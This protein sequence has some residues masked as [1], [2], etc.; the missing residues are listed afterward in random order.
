MVIT[1]DY[2]QMRYSLAPEISPNH[3]KSLLRILT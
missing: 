1:S 3:R 2:Q